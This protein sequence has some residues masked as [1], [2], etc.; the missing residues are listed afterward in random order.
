MANVNFGSKPKGFR[1]MP[2]GERTLLITK[3]EGIPRA[4]ITNV[5]AEFVDAEGITL[6]NSYNLTIDGGY[7]AFYYL[8]TNG[9][10][11][12]LDGDFDIDQL[13]G[14]FVEVNIVHKDGTKA[15]EDGTFPVFAN[16]GSTLGV[17]TPF[18]VEGGS[19]PVD[20]EDEV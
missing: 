16:I 19:E 11:V 1:L 15:R 7:A 5:K 9:L 6:K 12:E 8:V 20:D 4:K 17:G 14:K 3:I 13:Q 18:A 10:G 2:E